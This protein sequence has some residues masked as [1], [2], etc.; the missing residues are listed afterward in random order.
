MET[1]CTECQAIAAQLRVALRELMKQ[2]MDPSI[3]REDLHNFLNKLFSSEGE[4][5]RSAESFEIQTLAEL[6]RDGPTIGSPQ[7]TLVQ[8]HRHRSTSPSI[9]RRVRPND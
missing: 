2:P 8:E 6:T 9:L 7:A 3:S 4:I 1:K 5:H